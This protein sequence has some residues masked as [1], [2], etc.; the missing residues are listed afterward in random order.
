MSRWVSPYSGAVADCRRRVSPSPSSGL[1]AVAYSSVASANCFDGRL[2]MLPLVPS[3]TLRTG[4]KPSGWRGG[5]LS[6]W[7]SPL[8]TRGGRSTSWGCSY[9]WHASPRFSSVR[10]AKRLCG[11]LLMLPL[12]PSVKGGARSA[13]R[14]GRGPGL[15]RWVSPYS[16]A[17]ADCRR[18]VSPSPSSRLRAV[19][20]SSVASANCF[21]GRLPM[22]PLVPSV[23]LRTGGKPS[24]WRGPGLSRWVSP[25]CTFG[26]A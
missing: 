20:Y 3:V 22:L 25:C 24:G 6:G 19:A 11:R 15:S 23:T 16:G 26:R 2:P 10:T 17:V 8:P 1:R 7:V 9:F 12:V 14:G 5:R 21:D 4:G 18:R 13:R